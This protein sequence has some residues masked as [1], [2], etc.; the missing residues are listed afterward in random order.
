MVLKGAKD[1][2]GTPN[3]NR[4]APSTCTGESV[5]DTL[6]VTVLG[7]LAALLCTGVW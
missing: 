6:M 3:W 7:T 1:L 5:G 2:P 4:L